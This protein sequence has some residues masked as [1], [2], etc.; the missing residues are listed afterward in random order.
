MSNLK[1]WDS[2]SKSDTKYVK[3]GVKGMS[4]IDAQ[5]YFMKATKTFGPI[6]IGWGYEIVDQ[7]ITEGQTMKGNETQANGPYLDYKISQ[8]T[9]KINFWYKLDGEKGQLTQYGHTPLVMKT[10]Y[11]PMMDDDPEKKS[12]TDAIKKSLTML[13][14]SADVF[15]GMFDDTNYIKELRDEENERA[16]KE[17]AAKIAEAIDSIKMII[18]D[19]K[20]N[21]KKATTVAAVNALGKAD[22]E[23][24]NK[25]C[26]KVNQDPKP[27]I[28]KLREIAK[29]RN[30]EIQNANN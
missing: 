10:K 8:M 4:S 14:F 2:V 20:S 15:L 9:V 23:S 29:Q 25:L 13:G 19:A 6:G 16:E 17:K 24:I 11:G 3:S 12:L 5:Y 18:H 21:Y 1:L 22:S 27:P 26:K 30:Q 28:D 7:Y